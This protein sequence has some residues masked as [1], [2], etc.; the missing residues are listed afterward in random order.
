MVYNGYK[1]ETWWWE[2]PAGAW[3]L[4]REEKL[5]EANEKIKN[6]PWTTSGASFAGDWDYL[7]WVEGQNW[8]EVW[9]HLFEMKTENWQTSTFVPIRSWWN[10]N[11]KN[12]WW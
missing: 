11:W 1:N 4:V 7:A 5:D 9:G 12:N 2:K 3:V 10:Q 6:W 8:D